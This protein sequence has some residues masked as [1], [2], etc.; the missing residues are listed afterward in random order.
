[1]SHNITLSSVR[2]TDLDLLGSIVN[3]LSGGKAVLDKN[4]KNFRTFAGQAT[5][6]DA[7]IKMPGRHDVGLKLNADGKSYSP[8]FD[9][10]RMDPVFK[11][12]GA[13]NYIGKLAQEYALQEAEYQAAQMGAATTRVPGARGQVTLE[14]VQA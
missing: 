6:C 12:D 2:F 3:D 9:P 11:H 10:Y 14:I 7:A 8:V 5:N 4:A 13:T 1:M